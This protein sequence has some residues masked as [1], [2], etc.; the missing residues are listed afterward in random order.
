MDDYKHTRHP[1]GRHEVP[2][3]KAPS[4]CTASG[5][6]YNPC[7]FNDEGDIWSWKFNRSLLIVR[8]LSLGHTYAYIQ[9]RFLESEI[10]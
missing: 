8:D 3:S 1:A 7:L 5:R 2:S 6:Q 4:K 9:K 10:L